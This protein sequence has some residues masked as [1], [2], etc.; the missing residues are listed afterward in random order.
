MVMISRHTSSSTSV[1]AWCLA[2]D[3]AGAVVITASLQLQWSVPRGWPTC[4]SSCVIKGVFA[5]DVWHQESALASPITNSSRAVCF[6]D[7]RSNLMAGRIANGWELTKQSWAVLMADKKLMFFPMISSAACLLVLASFAVP[8]ALSLDWKAITSGSNHNL[9]IQIHNPVYYALL[10]AFYFVN[11]FLVVF[12]NSALVACVHEQFRGGTPSVGFGLSAAASRLPQILMWSLV[13]ATVG[14][15]LQMIADRS[16]LVGEIVAS[17][18]GAGWTI[19]TYFAVPVLVVEKVGPFQVF[20]R[21]VELLKKSWGESLVANWGIGLIG[22]IAAFLAAIPMV[23]GFALAAS[24]KSPASLVVGIVLS[25][26]LWL[27]IGLVSSTMKVIVTTALYNYAAGGAA[28][29]PFDGELLQ[30]AFKAK[31]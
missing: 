29:G 2:L 4:D 30:G 3:L 7:S 23:L 1:N 27:M 8:L 28:P 10:F 19:A 20:S 22:F 12:F 18:L 21:S 6:A 25:V 26:I 31:A 14:V 24:Q 17:L 5:E 13:S 16:K 15:I 11:Y 9:N